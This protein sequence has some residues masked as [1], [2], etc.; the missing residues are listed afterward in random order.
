ML[1]VGQRVVAQDEG[2]R[3][4]VRVVEL[5]RPRA[6]GRHRVPERGPL[7]NVDQRADVARIVGTHWGDAALRWGEA[8]GCR[9]GA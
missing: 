7:V 9:R 4:R 6:L 8:T 5:A 1:H 3:A 2:R